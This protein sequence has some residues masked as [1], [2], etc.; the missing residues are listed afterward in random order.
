M[1]PGDVYSLDIHTLFRDAHPKLHGK[2]GVAWCVGPAGKDWRGVSLVRY[3]LADV[4]F[5]APPTLAEVRRRKLRIQTFSFS[6]TPA[7]GVYVIEEGEPPRGVVHLGKLTKLPALRP[8]EQSH[9]NRASWRNFAVSCH[10]QWRHDHDQEALPAEAH[11]AQAKTRGDEEA[12]RKKRRA[13]GL[14]ALARRKLVPEWTGLVSKKRADA[15]RKILSLAIA[16]LRSEGAT[17]TTKLA[18]LETAVER[19]NA[20]NDKQSCFIDTPEREALMTCLG[21][22]AAVS[23]LGTIDERLDEWRD[24]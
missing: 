5:D 24:W 16:E 18:A 9:A 7:P 12:A 23:G 6:L 20:Y 4:L 17:K 8:A 1:V 10:F 22:L 19:I 13:G 11:R 3:A 15:V 14:P 21:D 2:H